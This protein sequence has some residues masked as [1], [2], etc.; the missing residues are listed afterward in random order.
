MKRT[1]FRTYRSF[2]VLL[3]AM[4]LVL[5]A[6]NSEIPEEFKKLEVFPKDIAKRDLIDSMK[7]ISSALGVRCDF[8]HEIEEKI[9]NRSM[10]L[11]SYLRG[12][13]EARLSEDDR[14]V[15]LDWAEQDD[16]F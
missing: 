5:P 8:C 9:G 6:A 12:H 15:L 7:K 16:P 3:A 4:F 10:P 11:E 2:Y 14:R 1:N 13:P